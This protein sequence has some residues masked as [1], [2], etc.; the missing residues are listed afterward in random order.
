MNSK[1]SER[2]YWASRT[3]AVSA[4]GSATFSQG[5]DFQYL[6]PSSC[7]CRPYLTPVCSGAMG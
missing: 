1:Q 2:N 3:T 6:N 5:T 7:Q 4:Q